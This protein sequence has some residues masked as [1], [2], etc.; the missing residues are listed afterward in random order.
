MSL[1][2]LEVNSLSK[3]PFEDTPQI[4]SLHS[5]A[6]FV[7][8]ITAI[9]ALCLCRRRNTP[10]VQ[11]CHIVILPSGKTVGITHGSNSH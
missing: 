9:A 11:T 8:L 5:L 4:L 7:V 1:T 6:T 2:V 10:V 3:L